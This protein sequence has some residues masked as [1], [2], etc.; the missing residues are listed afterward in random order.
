MKWLTCFL[1]IYIA[2]TGTLQAE[3]LILRNNLQ[4]AQPGDFLVISANKTQTLLHI[5]A[6]QDP[7]LT[8]EEIAIP[9]GKRPSNLNWQD[10]LSKNAPGNTSWVMYDIDLRTG[11]MVRYYSFTKRNWFEIPDGD[12]FL[13]KLLNLRLS[14][15]PNDARK[16]VGPKPT[17]GPDWR[18]LWQPRMVINGQ[19][20]KGVEFDA[21]RTKWPRD[22][23]ELSGKT[24]EVYVPRDS[25]RYPSYF[26]YWLQ[27][28]GVVGKAKIRIIDSGS[29]LQ[30]PKPPL[31]ALLRTT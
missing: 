18:P 29:Q 16:R 11:Q 23:S 15:I 8:V 25:Q 13:F 1:C 30:S 9:E 24:I 5:Y 28:N 21:W 17:S 7:I 22:N 4:R 31:S 10:W 2:W 20:I 14:Q 19:P 3:G 12:N 26:P 6:K 27:I